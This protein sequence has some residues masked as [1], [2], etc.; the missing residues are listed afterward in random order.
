M[1]IYVFVAKRNVASAY[2]R[3]IAPWRSKAYRSNSVVFRRSSLRI[4]VA[5]ATYRTAPLS[6]KL[7]KMLAKQIVQD[8]FTL[9]AF[10][11]FIPFNALGRYHGHNDIL[12]G[13]CCLDEC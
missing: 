2:R 8:E 5:S 3:S 9:D 6:D 13:V 1:T 11:M 4:V 7:L 12:V 10:G